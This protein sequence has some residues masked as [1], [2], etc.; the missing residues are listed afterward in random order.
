METNELSRE[1]LE[2]K[3]KELEE[4]RNYWMDKSNKTEKKYAT[5]RDMVKGLVFLVD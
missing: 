4:S 5:F 1:Q 3:V 2:A